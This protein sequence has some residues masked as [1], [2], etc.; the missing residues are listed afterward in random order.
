MLR[1]QHIDSAAGLPPSWHLSG[2]N[3]GFFRVFF[4]RTS[5]VFCL[6]G[7]WREWGGI[8]L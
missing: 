2:A 5:F 3:H 4:R 7:K 8:C 1:Q 6:P